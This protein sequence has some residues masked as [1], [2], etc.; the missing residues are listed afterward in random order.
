MLSFLVFPFVS[1]Q[2]LPCIWTY[3]PCTVHHFISPCQGVTPSNSKGGL[4]A[5]EAGVHVQEGG[6]EGR[7]D[8]APSQ[9]KSSQ[10]KA[11]SGE[12]QE[13]GGPTEKE[14]EVGVNP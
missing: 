9:S 2:F 1:N 3:L 11:E 14:A 12:E 5:P 4:P 7:I 13:P 6:I 8:S 10:D